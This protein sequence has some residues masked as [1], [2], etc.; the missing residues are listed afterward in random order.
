MGLWG[1]IIDEGEKMKENYVYPA[2]IK[3]V[4]EGYQLR[5]LDFPN[6][7]LIEENTK[8][9]LIKSAQE[10]LAIEILDYESKGQKL[11]EA[12]ESDTDVVYIHVWMPYYRNIAKEIYVK[13]TVTI[14]QW[15]DILAKQN[16]IN[17]SAAM[18]KGIKDELGIGK[19][20]N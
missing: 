2:Y 18:V 4:E 5:F 11:P 17:Y 1:T 16:K 12:S 13:K 3:K 15:L 8:T 9:E 14:P 10:C 20:S 7:T 19:D 6:M